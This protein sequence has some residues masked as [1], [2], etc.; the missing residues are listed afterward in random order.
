MHRRET[1]PP[2]HTATHKVTME[3]ITITNNGVSVQ[4]IGTYQ[5][6][7][8]FLL[9]FDAQVPQTVAPVTVKEDTELA[10]FDSFLTVEL[11]PF[12]GAKESKM[13]VD[14][15]IRC[16]KLGDFRYLIPTYKLVKDDLKKRQLLKAVSAVYRYKFGGYKNVD[17]YSL[18]SEI[19]YASACHECGELAKILVNRLIAE[20]LWK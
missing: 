13:I 17:K 9:G 19:K 14:R 2:T 12:F 15:L 18:R 11:T 20:G 3:T 4:V 16:R 10:H 6:V 1:N 7:A 5:D 8:K